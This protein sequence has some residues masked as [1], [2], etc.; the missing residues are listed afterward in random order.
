MSEGTI[1][2]RE[3]E[4]VRQFSIMLQNR[5]GALGAL[6]RMV[7]NAH[8]EIIGLSM[9]DSRDATVVRLVT[10]DPDTLMCLF[11][12]KGISHTIC[13]LVVVALTETGRGLGRC[14]DTL[15]AAETNVDFAYSL[16]VHPDQQSLLALHLEDYQFGAEMLL[17]AGFKLMFQEDL[18][19]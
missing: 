2:K 16:L 1:V 8:I 17:K 9:Q 18:A 11:A 5:A 15:M 10:T 12:E 6:V 13:D 14:L 3:G 7:R 4:P 19:R